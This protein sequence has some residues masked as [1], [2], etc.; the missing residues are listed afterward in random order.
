M[1][2][3]SPSS[4]ERP[5]THYQRFGKGRVLRV[6][7]ELLRVILHAINSCGVQEL[8]GTNKMKV[9]KFLTKVN[10][11]APFLPMPV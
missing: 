2:G 5:E 3:E 6:S 7:S 8:K 10:D 1:L 11:M 9:L 4:V